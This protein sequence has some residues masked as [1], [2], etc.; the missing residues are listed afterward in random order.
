MPAKAAESERMRAVVVDKQTTGR[1]TIREVPV[2]QP[3]ASEA[4]VRVA[5]VS[6]NRGETRTALSAAAD[7]WRPGWDLAGVVEHAAADGSGPPAGTRVVGLVPAGAWAER[8]AVSTQALATLPDM[9]SFAQAATL[10]V[11]GLTALPA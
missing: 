10:P 4:L 7:G 1:R 11:A 9:V 6:L 2:P 5:A 8:V 3:T